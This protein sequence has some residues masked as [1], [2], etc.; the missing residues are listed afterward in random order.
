MFR[1]GQTRLKPEKYPVIVKNTKRSIE[2]DPI[3]IARLDAEGMADLQRWCYICL[4]RLNKVSR[5]LYVRRPI[6]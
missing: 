3:E 5:W 4:T 1:W 6:G 2:S